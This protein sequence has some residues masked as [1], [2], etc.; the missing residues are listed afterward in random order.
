MTK[1]NKYFI[2]R[3]ITIFLIL[4]F[5]IVLPSCKYFKGG[6]FGKKSKALAIMKAREDSTRVA[7]SIQKVQLRLQEIEQAKLD[8]ARIAGEDMN[9]SE[10]KYKYNI[11][12]G[13]FITPEYAKGLKEFYRNK[14][15]D[16][17]I[18]K[19]DGSQFELVS[20]EGYDSFVKAFSRLKQFQDTILLDSWLYIKK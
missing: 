1:T 4:G 7:D 13:S 9:G 12:V 19:M 16:P 5:L 17:K 8:S 2:M 6:L 15:Y 20:A 3:N 18:I 14:G 10:S 11:I